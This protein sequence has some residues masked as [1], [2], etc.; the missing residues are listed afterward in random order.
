[1]ALDG[2]QAVAGLGQHLP[3]DPKT[4]ILAVQR[5]TTPEHHPTT[6]TNDTLKDSLGP[7]AL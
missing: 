1:M 5:Q 2:T 4:N 6:C 7:R 3:R